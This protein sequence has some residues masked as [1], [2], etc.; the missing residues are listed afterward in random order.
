MAH[1]PSLFTTSAFTLLVIALF[2]SRV[3]ASGTA[4]SVC[5]VTQNATYTTHAPTQPTTTSNQPPST[6]SNLVSGS[7][8]LEPLTQILLAAFTGIFATFVFGM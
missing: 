5:T 2:A 7:G 3:L 8:T 4:A 1:T 6:P